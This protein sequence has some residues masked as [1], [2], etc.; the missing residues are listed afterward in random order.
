LCVISRKIVVYCIEFRE[1][2]KPIFN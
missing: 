2:G 1:Y